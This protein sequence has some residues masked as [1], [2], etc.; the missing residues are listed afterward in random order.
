LTS[1]STIER[2]QA[3]VSRGRGIPSPEG[4]PDAR[5]ARQL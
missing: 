4:P 3:R 1:S 2:I 5:S